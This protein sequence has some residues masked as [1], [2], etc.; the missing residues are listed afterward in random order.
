MNSGK[1]AAI[2]MN[3][4]WGTSLAHGD[5]F[6]RLLFR[7]EKQNSMSVDEVK[8]LFASYKR[9]KLEMNE[10]TKECHTN[11]TI[12]DR[13]AIAYGETLND[14]II[15]HIETILISVKCNEPD[16]VQKLIENANDEA[17]MNE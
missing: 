7:L 1:L 17:R 15:L 12:E 4:D 16:Y 9:W 11:S 3:N 8:S 14:D 13:K 5:H 6:Y 2:I 10:L